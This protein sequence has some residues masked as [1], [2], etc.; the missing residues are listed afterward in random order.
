MKSFFLTFLAVFKNPQTRNKIFITLWLLALYRFLVYIPVPFADIS[1]IQLLQTDSS[2]WVWLF[3][4]LLWGT[5]DQFSI[6]AVGLG[7]YINASII[8]QLMWSVVPHLE[9]LQE[10][11]ESWNMKLQQY[12]RYL[13]FPLAFLQ[14][15]G[16]VYFINFYL[17]GSW[18]I[19]VI[20]ISN[21]YTVF[22]ATFVLSVWSMLLLWIWELIT[23]KWV[24]N[25]VSLI[26]FASIVSWIS[27]SV[28]SS[29]SSAT[30]TLWVIVFML[31]LVLVLI[32]L[33]ILIL[34]SIK[35]IPVVYSKQWKIQQTSS[36]PIPMNPVWMIPIIFAM[37]FVSFPYLISQ[38]IVKVWRWWSTA[39]L[40]ATRI[41]QNLNINQNSLNYGVRLYFILIVL[42]TF[43]YT[44]IV[45]NPEK[46]ADSI[47]KKWWF[48]PGMRPWNDTINYI[49]KILMHLCLWWWLWLAFVGIYSYVINDIPF[50]KSLIKDFWTLP[51][52]VTWSWI[53]IIVWVV[54]DV[55]NK[56]NSDLLMEKYDRM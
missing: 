18:D 5:I 26:I 38:I 41:E 55:L 29:L 46:M 21:I 17:K 33:S 54:Q 22:W 39:S 40:I 48:I 24:S 16:M 27:N 4:L 8:M 9:E 23:E 52:V 31:V 10:Q 15:F 56:I 7:P 13:S 11:W 47:Q 28:A 51:L 2:W 42:F 49:N 19:N 53:I 43:F 25:W 20:D 6:L 1:Q 35:K 30:N 3:L 12:T 45:F 32:I 34:K 36:L 37:A 44:I 14:S 50:I